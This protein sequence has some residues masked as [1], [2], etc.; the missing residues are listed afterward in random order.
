MMNLG[1]K[2]KKKPLKKSVETCTENMDTISVI[3]TAYDQHYVTTDHVREVMKSTL[4]PYEVI[5]VN[6][7]GHPSLKGMLGE[8]LSI[9]SK[10]QLQLS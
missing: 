3:V 7:G 4:T 6:D 5:V 1:Q 9:G 2:N 8:L 10:L